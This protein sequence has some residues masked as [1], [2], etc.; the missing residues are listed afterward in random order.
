MA[1]LRATTLLSFMIIF[2]GNRR[3][4]NN[5]LGMRKHPDKPPYKFKTYNWLFR[6]T[7]LPSAT[8][9]FTM[10][11][12]LDANERR[13]AGKI[14]RHINE[15]GIGFKALNDP[16]SALGRYRLLRRLHENNINK[17]N[18][19]LAI[20]RPKPKSFPVFI[21]QLSVSLPPLTG[22]LKN[23]DELDQ[24]II[25]LAKRG[26]P[27]EDLVVIEYCSEPYMGE[28]FVKMSAYRI[29]DQ[30]FT[31]L[32]IYSKGW[33]VKWNGPDVAPANAAAIEW[34]L[35]HRNAYVEEA[36]KVFELANV[37]YGRVDFSLV[38]GQTQF[39]EVNFNPQFT[40]DEYQTSDPQRLKNA[41]FAADRRMDAMN[42]LVQP[43][44]IGSIG[45]ICDPDI[46]A[47]RLRPWRNY[48]PQRY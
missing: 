16:A 4:R 33:Y 20:D 38:G 27:L 34:D 9:I 45:N 7:K 31:D 36:K 28:H 18:A 39:Y 35:L 47:F 44:H 43:S 12:R 5:L 13:L 2:I 46:T 26:E 41:I 10:V 21:R 19:Y 14:Y 42:T 32:F 37:E 23:Q 22:L 48:A 25:E 24:Q 29:N 40:T 6:T 11:D 8:Y 1:Q 3:Q 15:A 17:F 30:Y